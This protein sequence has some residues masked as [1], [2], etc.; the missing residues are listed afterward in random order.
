MTNVGEKKYPG[1]SREEGKSVRA[2]LAGTS[3]P[4]RCPWRPALVQARHSRPWHLKF[5]YSMTSIMK[6]RKK[7]SE[8]WS[9]GQGERGKVRWRRLSV[10]RPRL[11]EPERALSHCGPRK[12]IPSQN[13]ITGMCG[14]LREG[15]R[16][17]GSG[18]GI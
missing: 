9:Q 18:S 8:T 1:C 17:N 15:L 16:R 2:L 11:L 5:I 6:I 3:R 12:L 4:R 7:Y 10:S 13:T 14:G